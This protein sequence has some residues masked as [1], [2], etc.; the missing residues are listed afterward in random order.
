MEAATATAE[1]AHD[2]HGAHGHPIEA[3]NS[4]RLHRETF[5][6]LIF[7]VSEIMLFGSFFMAYFFIRVVNGEEW[8]PPGQE[9]PVWVAFANSAILISSSF[10]LHWASHG[11]KTGNRVALKAGLVMTILLGATFLGIQI[12]EYVSLG[13]AP[14][15]SAQASVF[16]SLTGIHGAHVLV[17]LI[18]LITVAVRAF[19]GHYSP[20]SHHGVEVPGIYWHFVDVMWIFV[21][22]SLYVL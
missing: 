19:R 17:G 15:A 13:F 18:I 7:I 10:T 9:L 11:I 6:M 2:D 5:G 20:E 4:S 8:M 12:N 14:A 1:H 22:T 3:H 21:F 16:F